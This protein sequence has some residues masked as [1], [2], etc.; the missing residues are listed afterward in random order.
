MKISKC[1]ESNFYIGS[2]K[3]ILEEGKKKV[4]KVSL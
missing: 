3:N 1:I 2:V 4:L